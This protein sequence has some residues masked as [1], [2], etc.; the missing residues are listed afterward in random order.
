M[1][2]LFFRPLAFMKLSDLKSYTRD[3]VVQIA[4]RLAHLFTEKLHHPNHFVAEKN[5]KTKSAAQSSLSCKNG[6]LKVRIPGYVRN[7]RGLAA[8]PDAAGQ[9]PV[10]TKRALARNGFEPG[11]T[12]R[13]V[14]P[15]TEATP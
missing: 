8:G 7:P 4:I 14:M 9:A 10:A 15:T 3:H 13:R 1:G 2:Q 6:S 11:Q 12:H 5:W